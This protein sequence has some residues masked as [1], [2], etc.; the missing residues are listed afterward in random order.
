MDKRQKQE[1]VD[2]ISNKFEKAKSIIFADYRGLN[3]E[4]ITDLRRKLSQSQSTIK[5]VKNRLAKRAAK[6][7][8]VSG[9]DGYLTGPTAMASSEIDPVLPAKIMVDFAKSHEPLSIKAGF[10]DGK[11]IDLSVIMTL[12]TLPSRDVL[13]A[14]ALR[15][16]N[17][18][19][20]NF[21]MALAAI[22]RQLVTVIDAVRKTKEK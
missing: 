9:L 12:A 15:S 21:T 10:M 2:Y 22:P 1:Q 5:V 11:V 18:P 20:T 4:A 7:H 19:I 17:A 13:L 16:M 6:S 3:V 14:R 8:G